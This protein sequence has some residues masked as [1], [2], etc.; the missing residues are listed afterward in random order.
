MDM[1]ADQA[2][3]RL[4]L[5]FRL[6]QP[7]RPPGTAEFAKGKLVSNCGRKQSGAAYAHFA[8]GVHVHG[9]HIASSLRQ[10]PLR[11]AGALLPLRFRHRIGAAEDVICSAAVAWQVWHGTCME[12][13]WLVISCIL[14]GSSPDAAS[15]GQNRRT[16]H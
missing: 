15:V 10:R 16:P 12:L 13:S 8:P 7:R 9:G 1:P 11:A 2:R 6:R 4:K 3:R 14:T 5:S